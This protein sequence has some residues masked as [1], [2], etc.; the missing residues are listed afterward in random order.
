MP[1]RPPPER[2]RCREKRQGRDQDR[3]HQPDCDSNRDLRAGP[4]EQTGIE[5]SAFSPLSTNVPIAPH[6]APFHNPHAEMSAS[7][8]FG[9]T[10]PALRTDATMTDS[11]LLQLY[12][13]A[14]IYRI[15]AQFRTL[16][17]VTDD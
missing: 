1:L 15:A 2:A 13:F 4:S 12:E 10:T 11:P 3:E 17:P 9:R 8:V 5:V 7:M 14:R 16:G 6:R